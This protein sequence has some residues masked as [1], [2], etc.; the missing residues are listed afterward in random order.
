MTEH[1]NQNLAE[2]ELAVR[3]GDIDD[4]RLTHP[5]LRDRVE[6]IVQENLAYRQAFRDF[7]ATDINS[8]VVEIPVPQDDMENPSVVGEGAEFPREQENYTNESLT[9]KKFGFEVALTHEAQED[10][11]IDVV[12]DQVD[13]QARQ[14]AEEMNY[15]AFTNLIN[16]I[17]TTVGDADGVLSYDDLLDGRKELLTNNYDPDLLIADVEGVHDLMGDSNFLEAETEA[18]AEMRREGAVGRVLGMDVVEADDGN[19]IT[20][21]DNPGAVMVDTDYFGYEGT[22]ETMTSEDYEEQRTQ[23][24]VYRVYNRLGWLTIQSNSGVII[25]G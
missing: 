21:N 7:D 22:R 17:G 6:E 12:R 14:M 18:N 9:F 3:M 4:F 11:M 2:E 19:N 20:G 5:V 24:D 13:R 23:T 25:E 1:N 8:N 16:G 15:Q 10:S